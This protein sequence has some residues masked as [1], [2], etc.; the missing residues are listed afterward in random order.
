MVA[1]SYWLLLSCMIWQVCSFT[2]VLCL[3]FPEPGKPLVDFAFL[4]QST[5]SLGRGER[6][7]SRVLR[8]RA[9]AGEPLPG[10]QTCQPSLPN[11]RQPMRPPPRIRPLMRLGSVRGLPGPQSANLQICRCQRCQAALGLP[12]YAAVVQLSGHTAL[13]EISWTFVGN[14]QPR[15]TRSMSPS[16]VKPHMLGEASLDLSM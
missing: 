10:A 12:R 2:S 11:P 15:F 9:P 4:L 3:A 1:C 16:T 13:S 7:C 8:V 14:L 6:T 5:C